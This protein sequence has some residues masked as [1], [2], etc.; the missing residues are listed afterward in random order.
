MGMPK[1]SNDGNRQD[2]GADRFICFYKNDTPEVSY[3][4]S[5]VSFVFF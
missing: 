4:T 2:A 5:G 3:P 1:S